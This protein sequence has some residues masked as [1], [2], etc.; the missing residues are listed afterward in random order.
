LLTPPAHASLKLERARYSRVDIDMRIR[1]KKR[2]LLLLS[3]LVALSAAGVANAQSLG[4]FGSNGFLE[5]DSNQPGS[6]S[7]ISDPTATAPTSKVYRFSVSADFCSSQKYK[8]GAS[9]DC[10]FQSVRSL[11]VEDVW[12]QNVL[13]Q[14]DQLWYGWYM[15]L[16]ADFPL[17][18]KQVSGQYMFAEFHNGQCP[19]LALVNQT[20][21][22]NSLYLVSNRAL[23]GYRCAQDMKIKVGNL[24]QMLGRWVRFEMYVDWSKDD[25]AVELYVDGQA[26]VNYEGRTLTAGYEDLNHF[27]FGM[28]LCCTAG[29]RLVQDATVLF[30]GVKSAS[31]RSGLK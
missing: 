4:K 12:K 18:G 7:R 27:N 24:Q 2:A 6:Y 30:A 1:A 8:D 17:K 29:V 9:D 3:T 19:H 25:G 10:K 13:V 16:P 20:N 28:Y 22:S 21:E 26:A 11:L 14:P 15:Y 31:K 23:G 5:S